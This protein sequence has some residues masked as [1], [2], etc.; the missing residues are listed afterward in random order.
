MVCVYFFEAEKEVNLSKSVL[1]LKDVFIE[2]VYIAFLEEG[3]HKPTQR[4]N[5]PLYLTFANILTSICILCSQLCI[6]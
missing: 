2:F 5:I 6:S 3:N 1:T 4:G